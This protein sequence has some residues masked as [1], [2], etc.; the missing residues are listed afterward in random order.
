[1]KANVLHFII[2]NWS[3]IS[4]PFFYVQWHQYY[5]SLLIVYNYN[6]IEWTTGPY[7]GGSKDT[8]LGGVAAQVHIVNNFICI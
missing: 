7:G 3:F 5:F 8:G 6:K 1:M 4:Y 2:N